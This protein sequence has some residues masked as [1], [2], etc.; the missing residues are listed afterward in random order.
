MF[1][2]LNSVGVEKIKFFDA[3]LYFLAKN[4]SKKVNLTELKESIN[5]S[6]SRIKNLSVI[7]SFFEEDNVKQ[8]YQKSLNLLLDL[9]YIVQDIEQYSLTVNGLVTITSGGLL[10]KETREINKYNYQNRIW[11]IILLTFLVNVA[12]QLYSFSK[13]SVPCQTCKMDTKIE[14]NNSKHLIIQQKKRK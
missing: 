5:Y 12:F 7:D 3:I 4:Y 8:T 10:G 11:V 2:K 14:T 13:S 6:D 1:F 9:G